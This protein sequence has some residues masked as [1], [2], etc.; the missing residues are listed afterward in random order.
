MDR[1]V[2]ANR[3]GEGVG[4]LHY[5]GMAT[6]VVREKA[7]VSLKPAHLTYDRCCLMNCK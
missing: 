7:R 4:A 5:Q 1:Y 3:V 6:G 2:T